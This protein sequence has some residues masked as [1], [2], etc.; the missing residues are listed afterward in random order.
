MAEVDVIGLEHYDAFY[1][2]NH[3]SRCERKDMMVCLSLKRDRE[4]CS[5]DAFTTGLTQAARLY[6]SGNLLRSQSMI[7]V[8]KTEAIECKHGFPCSASALTI[9]QTGSF[10]TASTYVSAN[11]KQKTKKSGVAMSISPTSI[12]C[13]VLF[14]ALVFRRALLNFMTGEDY[15]LV[16]DAWGTKGNG[17]AFRAVHHE[18]GCVGILY[19]LRD[20][21]MLLEQPLFGKSIASNDAGK[22]SVGPSSSLFVLDVTVMRTFLGLT[23]DFGTVELAFKECSKTG[24]QRGTL[25]YHHCFS[26]DN[27]DKGTVSSHGSEKSE[28][29]LTASFSLVHLH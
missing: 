12:T 3:G 28:T 20:N 15:N 8:L 13:K 11:Q 7:D 2:Y 19:L 9:E 17:I 24:E 4:R 26:N 10:V 14:E 16:S 25:A 27:S 1:M 22:I 21:V 6:F 29:L 5:M 18:G 23:I